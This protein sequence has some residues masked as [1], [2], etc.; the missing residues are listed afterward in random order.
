MA[1][2]LWAWA[3]EKPELTHRKRARQR[4]IP[5]VDLIIILK[6]KRPG[7]DSSGVVSGMKKTK[8]QRMIR[9]PMYCPLPIGQKCTN[10]NGC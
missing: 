9:P 1:V 3:G 7:S 4:T 2:L 6:E 10:R 5:H 8:N